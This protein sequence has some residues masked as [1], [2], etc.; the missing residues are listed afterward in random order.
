MKILN[1]DHVKVPPFHPSFK[2]LAK[3]GCKHIEEECKTLNKKVI[4]V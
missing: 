2:K 3:N 4:E 1:R